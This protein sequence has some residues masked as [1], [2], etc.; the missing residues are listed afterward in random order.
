MLARSLFRDGK[1]AI[2]APTGRLGARPVRACPRGRW[3]ADRAGRVTVA[4]AARL[5]SLQVCKP[6]W[7]GAP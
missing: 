1:F 6:G 2:G 5:Q 7:I 3:A 4:W